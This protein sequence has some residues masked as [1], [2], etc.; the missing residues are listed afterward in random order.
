MAHRFW[1][2]TAIPITGARAWYLI[3]ICI[4]IPCQE[5]LITC[6]LERE[7]YCFGP[8]LQKSQVWPKSGLFLCGQT[9]MAEADGTLSKDIINTPYLG[10]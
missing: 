2:P 8:N 7:E 4:L 9:A 5:K 1:E 10:I 6:K 3:L